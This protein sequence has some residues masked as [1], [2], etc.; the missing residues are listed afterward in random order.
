MENEKRPSGED[1]GPVEADLEKIGEVRGKNA[2]IC[3]G[4][5]Q[6]VGAKQHLWR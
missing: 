4:E 1:P 2:E 5:N 6:R 3:A